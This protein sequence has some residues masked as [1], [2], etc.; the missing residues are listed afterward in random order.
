MQR[1]PFLS[2]LRRLAAG[3]ILMAAAAAASAQARQYTVT[4]PDGVALAV[5]EAGDPDGPAVVFVHGLLGSHLSWAA[6]VASPALQRYRLITYDLR[7]HGLSGKPAAADAYTDGR[8]WADDLAAVI[9]A[10]GARA[11]VVVGWSLGAAVTTNYLAAYGDGAIA[12]AVYAG[13]VIELDAAQI[14]AH[15]EVYRGMASADLKTHLDAEREFL[16][17]C[18][19]Q[20]PDAAT[21]QRLL[22]NAALASFEMQ[23]AV[24]SM[25]IAAAQ[26][27]GAARK[28]ML[29]IYGARDALVNPGPSIDRAT[30]LNPRIRSAIYA[31]SG[32][33]PFL[34]EANRFNRDLSA[35]VDAA[36]GR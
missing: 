5:Q 27:L 16:G 9:A 30:G 7:G 36:N 1:N 11:P 2:R 21:L 18:F 12:G 3:A 13:G 31:Q 28:P 33:A 19:A 29:L 6:Q 23:A 15:P 25:T 17:L 26:G 34:E 14:A 24:P 35:F 8:R 4:A 32:H 20:Q 22:A 10:T